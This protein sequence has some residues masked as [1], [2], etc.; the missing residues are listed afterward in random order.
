MAPHLGH[1]NEVVLVGDC[2]W[3]FAPGAQD[4]WCMCWDRRH[5]IL[6]IT[7]P[8]CPGH[9]HFI[10]IPG[11]HEMVNNVDHRQAALL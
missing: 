1:L 8:F 7:M 11:K 9:W 4:I 5:L 10:H 2:N 6:F 3:S